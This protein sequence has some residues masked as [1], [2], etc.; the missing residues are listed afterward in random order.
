MN[1][2]DPLFSMPAEGGAREAL[3]EVESGRTA[4]FAD[5]RDEVR[6]VAGYLISVGVAHGDRVAIHLYNSIDAAV[7]HMAVQYVGA[8]SCWIDAL[9]QP[10]SLSYHV[11]ETKAKLLVTHS[12]CDDLPAEV[13]AQAKVMHAADLSL[14]GTS[15]T[16]PPEPHRFDL[17][18]ICYIYYT[19]GTTSLA[20]GV[21]LSGANHLNFFRITD[22]YWQP[23][24]AS[25]RH[26]CFVPFSHGFG[27][28]FLIPLVIRT[29]ARL[30]ILRSFHPQRV[31]DTI[32]QHQ[33]TH[34]YGVPS[35]Y[36]QLLRLTSCHES[37]RTLQMCFCAAAK[38]EQ[39]TTDR[40][41]KV[42]GC[43]LSEGYGLIET[44]C[45]IVWRVGIPARGTGHVGICPD[46]RL[47]ELSILD[48]EDRPLPVGE[49]GQ[50]AV[51]GPSIMKGYLDK[52]IQTAE[53]FSGDWFKTG[54]LGYLTP[55]GHL[56]MTGRIKDIINIAGIKVSPFEVEAVLNTHPG[57]AV[58][59]V[60]SVED[61]IYGEVV[62][63]FVQR[64][65]GATVTEREL[66]R[67]AAERLINF[68]VPKQIHF[69]E[70]FPLNNLGKVDRNKLRETWRQPVPEASAHPRDR[71]E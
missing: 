48:A 33:I 41:Q 42:T 54:D 45:G 31:A 70:S 53:V 6:R 43:H 13:L 69:V 30:Y 4:T 19:S 29:G 9:I 35:H 32:K 65:P 47:V 49:R 18:E 15:E 56:F 24:D 36:Q 21:M 16:C 61:Q 58:S 5:L 1:Y 27:T 38:L 52:P 7:L 37:L 51:R 34:L 50:I 66:I 67:Y 62:R 17:N 44:C 46:R 63:A 3:I 23:V 68:Q 25:S 22:Q 57:V 26:L 64:A 60:V 55:D 8:V 14:V 39:E 40:W 11:A 20:K 71:E 10:R 12:R 2:C 59:V 28:I